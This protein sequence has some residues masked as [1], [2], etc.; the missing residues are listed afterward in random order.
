MIGG[1]KQEAILALEMETL[2][3]KRGQRVTED[4]KIQR[5]NIRMTLQQ[6]K[7]NMGR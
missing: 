7:V 2:V 4:N 5:I 3:G 6:M 1:K